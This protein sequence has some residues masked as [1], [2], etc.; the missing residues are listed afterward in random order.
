MYS[1]KKQWSAANMYH[2]T[3]RERTDGTLEYHVC[4]TTH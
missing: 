4:Q 1:M 2:A 3:A